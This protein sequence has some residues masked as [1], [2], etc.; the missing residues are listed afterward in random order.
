MAP[1]F[2]HAY[3]SVSGGESRTQ[4]DEAAATAAELGLELAPVEF[5]YTGAFDLGNVSFRVVDPT[6]VETAHGVKAEVRVCMFG[7]YLRL[8]F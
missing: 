5:H 2:T 6:A 3:W 4:L 8:W 7:T 1:F